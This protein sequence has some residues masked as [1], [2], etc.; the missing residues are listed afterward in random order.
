VD[1]HPGEGLTIPLR[2]TTNPTAPV[3]TLLAYAY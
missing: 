1:K 2:Q 3:E